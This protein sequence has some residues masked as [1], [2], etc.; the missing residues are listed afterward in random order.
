MTSDTQ[1]IRDQALDWIIRQ[2]DAA[3]DDWEAFAT[4]LEAGPEHAAVYHAMADADRDVP[5][6]L[7]PVSRPTAIPTKG[8]LVARRA[9][10]VGALAASLVATVS[11]GV[12]EL[13]AAPYEVASAAG[14]PRLLTLAD[15][16]RIQMN[17]DTTLRLDRH[18]ARAVELVDG[19][20]VFTVVHDDAAPFALKVGPATL[21]DVGTVFN[22]ARRHG[23][24]DVEVAEGEVVF[25][26]KTENVRLSGGRWLRSVDKDTRLVIG[27]I[28]P[29][30][31]GAWRTG[32]LVYKDAVLTQVA[33]DLSRNL[34][35]RVVAAP[36]VAQR[37]FR[38]VISF[39]RDR[40][41]VMARLGPLLGVQVR[42]D[43]ERW[44]LTDQAG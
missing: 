29:G 19:E 44:L 40:E 21:L 37:K 14:Q 41:A 12:L 10:L 5:A 2:R 4:W 11:Y 38:G 23:T 39:G 43:G 26:P 35:L 30:V 31:V 32:R 27:E 16:T 20:A 15:G 17:G 13:R 9:W 33:E 8:R 22:V 6:M 7:P 28:E 3:F 42:H 34:G 24:T 18:D 1:A 36:A 25:N